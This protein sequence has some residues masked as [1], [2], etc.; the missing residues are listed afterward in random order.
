MKMSEAFTKMIQASCIKN[1]PSVH[2]LAGVGTV[3]GV[4]F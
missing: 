3:G 2:E 1:V 4:P